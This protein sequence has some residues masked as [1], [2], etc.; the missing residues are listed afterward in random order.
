MQCNLNGSFNIEV[1]VMI[2]IPNFIGPHS[3]HFSTNQFKVN[4]VTKKDSFSL[5]VLRGRIKIIIAGFFSNFNHISIY[6]F[7]MDFR[8]DVYKVYL[9]LITT[10]ELAKINVLLVD[11][12]NGLRNFQRVMYID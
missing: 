5:L 1:T 10:T 2:A 3:N 11:L 6:I 7:K 8:C 12:T 4:L 9:A